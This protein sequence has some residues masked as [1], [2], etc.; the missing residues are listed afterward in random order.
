MKIEDY[1][2]DEM[3]RLNRLNDKLEKEINTGNA[4]KNEPE[5]IVYN[6]N[7]M[8]EITNSLCELHKNNVK[9]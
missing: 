4:F 2:L 7:A 8:C 5:Q 3:K 6:A 1:L 9:I